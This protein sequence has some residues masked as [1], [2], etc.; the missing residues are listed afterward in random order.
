MHQLLTHDDLLA[1]A[2][3]DPWVRW[4]LANPLRGEAWVHEDVALVERVGRRRGFWV[5]PLPAGMPP[6]AGMPRGT[7]SS[8]RTVATPRTPTT[9][10]SLADDG[11]PVRAALI[12][13]RDG[14]HLDRL[15]SQSVSVPQEHAA[16]AHEVLD[17]AGGG[18]WD[19]MWTTSSPLVHPA[20]GRIVVLDDTED[21]G[22]LTAFTRLHNPRVWTEIGT[23]RVRRWVGIRGANRALV[24]VGGA[25]AEESGIPHLAGVVTDTALRGQGLASA[26]SAH[27]TRWA[28]GTHGVCTLGMFSD[29]EAAR[30]VYDRLNYRTAHAW[31][32]RGLALDRRAG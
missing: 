22:E 14:G 3:E 2:A 13:L 7:G 4:S 5:V 16:I 31:H 11:N 26:V 17:L 24:A 1:R 30:R 18:D 12:A 8:P 29:N 23:G 27:L 10:A 28:V 19:W 21:E 9:P 20:E 15:A 25:E 32:S 6:P